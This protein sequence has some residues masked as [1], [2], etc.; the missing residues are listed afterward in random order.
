MERIEGKD[1]GRCVK[2]RRGVKGHQIWEVGVTGDRVRDE[3]A[4]AEGSCG[5]R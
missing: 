5:L 3:R 4:R 1:K 2:R